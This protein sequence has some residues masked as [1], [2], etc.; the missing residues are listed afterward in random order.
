MTPS[1]RAVRSP[2]TSE[3]PPPKARLSTGSAVSPRG[4]R[5]SE[6]SG[7]GP[8]S[9]VTPRLSTVRAESPKNAR[10]SLGGASKTST[11]TE[12]PGP[13]RP[14]AGLQSPRSPRD[15]RENSKTLT[16]STRPVSP[17]PWRGAARS[18]TSGQTAR[19]ASPQLRRATSPGKRL[20][21]PRK[22]PTY[23]MGTS[24]S[25]RALGKPL[26][27]STI[28]SEVKSAASNAQ[29]SVATRKPI[30]ASK[31]DSRPSVPDPPQTTSQT[32]LSGCEPNEDVKQYTP[33]ADD[34][35]EDASVMAGLAQS[36]PQRT[37]SPSALSGGTGLNGR[38]RSSTMSGPLVGANSCGDILLGEKPYFRAGTQSSPRLLRAESSQRVDGTAIRNFGHMLGSCTDLTNPSGSL[39]APA[40]GSL[41]APV[42]G[43]NPSGVDVEF[44]VSMV[45]LSSSDCTS[46]ASANLAAIARI[47]SGHAGPGSMKV[48]LGNGGG[49]GSMHIPLAPSGGSMNAP[50]GPVAQ[51]PGGCRL[52]EKRP[53]PPGTVVQPAV[54]A[55]PC[56][57][58]A[59]P[60]GRAAA[61]TPISVRHRLPGSSPQLR[62]KAA[63]VRPP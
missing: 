55:A 4:L 19:P 51:S 23:S 1:S 17:G 16:A 43:G 36:A 58:T 2:R 10:T 40:A 30:G 28:A 59:M 9:A 12:S 63:I 8:T 35:L 53:N 34:G 42:A 47:A 13:S 24:S 45:D 5:P 39:A 46:G 62:L 38:M 26:G 11:R 61:T 41:T 54:I 25:Q 33:R 57:A 50:V 27:R 29:P 22:P 15:T 21:S 6:N 31:E 7:L 32:Q 20:E 49:G 14:T 52:V 18:S 56:A 60:A 48:P 44:N 37:S 3:A